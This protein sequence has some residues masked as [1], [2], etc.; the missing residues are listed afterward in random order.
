PATSQIQLYDANCNSLTLPSGV[1]TTQN[2]GNANSDV[3]GLTGLAPGTY[4]LSVKYDST[5]I[6]GLANPGTVTYSFYTNINGSTVTSVVNGL[7]LKKKA[8]TL[9]APPA[10][11]VQ[12]NDV[13]SQAALMAAVDQGIGYWRAQG[14]NPVAL[15]GLRTLNFTIESL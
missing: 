3:S 1:F 14:I 4:V 12:S 2:A 13:L 9:A 7:T 15:A 6:K 11:A 10:A 8:L 5:T